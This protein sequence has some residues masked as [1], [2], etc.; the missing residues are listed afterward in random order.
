MTHVPEIPGDTSTIKLTRPLILFAVIRA[1]AV[2][3]AVAIPL[4]LNLPKAN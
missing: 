3:I 1:L 4:G 2:A